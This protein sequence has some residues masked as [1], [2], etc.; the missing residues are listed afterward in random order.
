MI[1]G[2]LLTL[3]FNGE[4]LAIGAV[5]TWL[6]LTYALLLAGVF[7]VAPALMLVVMLTAATFWRTSSNPLLERTAT[8]PVQR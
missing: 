1:L 7:A 5:T 6:A 3:G 2:L 8:P 4:S